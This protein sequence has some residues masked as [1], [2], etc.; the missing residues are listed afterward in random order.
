MNKLFVLSGAS[1][2]GKSSL[3]K[4]VVEKGL[5]VQAAKYSNRIRRAYEFDD[6][7]HIEVDDLQTKCDIRYQIYNDNIWY[8]INTKE[9]KE[10]LKNGNLIVII[11]D[12]V[13][14]KTLKEYLGNDALIVFIYLK[15]LCIDNLLKKRYNLP[16]SDEEK[17]E[18]A[19][20]ILKCRDKKN[21]NW[22]NSV[23]ENVKSI[24]EKL[25]CG[26]HEK[27]YQ[28]FIKRCDS[29]IELAIKYENNKSLFTGGI[30]SG[31]VEELYEKF[32][33][34]IFKKYTI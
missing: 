29:W 17:T 12:I 30:I 2:S 20:Y 34:K 1:G 4:K 33:S 18:L 31:T 27:E 28:E 22:I 7:T 9:I 14:I 13:T 24:I 3:L 19:H 16:I 8:G 25:K 26:F 15:D 21:A 11:S 5:C 32:Y 23:P 10:K 6:I